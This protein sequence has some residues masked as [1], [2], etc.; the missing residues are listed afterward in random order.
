MSPN[1]Q[2]Q[3]LQRGDKHKINAF[4]K[5]RI[6]KKA[7]SLKKK[8]QNLMNLLTRLLKEGGG[9][10]W[11]PNKLAGLGLVVHPLMFEHDPKKEKSAINNSPIYN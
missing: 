10:K 1:G 5:N 2:Q 7:N 8:D 4:C 9:M 11:M 6:I 3:K